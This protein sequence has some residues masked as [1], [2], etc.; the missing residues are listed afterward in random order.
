MPT[1][2]TLIVDDNPRFR[3]AATRLLA[4]YEQ[5]EVVGSVPSARD[6]IDAVDT[7]NPEL[8]LMDLVMPGMNGLEATAEIKRRPTAPRVVIV[9]LEDTPEHR[10]RAKDVGADGVVGKVGLA[11]ELLPLLREMFPRPCG[12]LS[13]IPPS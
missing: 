1:V 13:E 9:T 7:L 11:T 12:N 3:D 8:V 4:T 6:A 10:V 5:L 2:R